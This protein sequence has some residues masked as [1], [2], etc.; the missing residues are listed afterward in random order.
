[1]ALKAIKVDDGKVYE[2]NAYDQSY[3]LDY[4]HSDGV[5]KHEEFSDWDKAAAAYSEAKTK[6][7]KEEPKAEREIGKHRLYLTVY[8]T[9]FMLFGE[10]FEEL[11]DW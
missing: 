1:M 6:W 3:R 9:E 10:D 5:W 11:D 4:R 7:D 2:V 8:K